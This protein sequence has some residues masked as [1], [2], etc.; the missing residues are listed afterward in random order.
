MNLGGVNKEGRRWLEVSWL[1]HGG[2]GALST[3]KECRRSNGLGNREKWWTWCR[4]EEF[5][6]REVQ[7]WTEDVFQGTGRKSRLGIKVLSQG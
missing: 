7:R 4:H 3:D 1:G 6:R 2:G 5:L